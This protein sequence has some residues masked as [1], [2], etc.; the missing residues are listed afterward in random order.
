MCTAAIDSDHWVSLVIWAARSVRFA[1]G[2]TMNVNGSD[3][4]HQRRDPERSPMTARQASVMSAILAGVSTFLTL[5]LAVPAHA[6]HRGSSAS[7]APPAD[8]ITVDVVSVN[9]S[10]CPAGS[11]TVTV[12]EDHTAFRVTYH[13]FSVTA[14]GASA[15]TDFRKNCQLN[16]LIHV[17]QGFTFAIASADYR[18]R[19]RLQDGATGLQRTNYYFQGSPDNN[20]VD[21]PFAGPL[22]AV[23][24]TTDTTP[25]AE[26]VFAPCG[27]FRN[28]NL[29]TEL[30]VHAG[31]VAPDKVSA[32]SMRTTDGDI[33][34]IFHFA[35]KTCP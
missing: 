5:T 1:A 15:P 25:V 22:R 10:G 28:L 33:D 17:P 11:A 18:G 2:I 19:A 6:G 32:M 21:H 26:L 12:L 23:W 14:G 13:D 34:T 24:H 4:T 29:N 35:W 20:F 8:A 30:R 31:T 27:V 9:G 16:L 3:D 7:D